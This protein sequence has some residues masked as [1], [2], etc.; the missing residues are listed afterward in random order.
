MLALADDGD[1]DA[2][3]ALGRL[4]FEGRA[5]RATDTDT[6]KDLIVS[7][8]TPAFEQDLGQAAKWLRK[9]AAQGHA[10][11]KQLLATVLAKAKGIH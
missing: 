11:A 3:A 4:Y 2:Q 10:E 1:A 9:A 7:S 8:F 6:G 5:E